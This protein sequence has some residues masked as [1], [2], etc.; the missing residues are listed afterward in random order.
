MAYKMHYWLVVHLAWV[1]R[2]V[3][4]EYFGLQNSCLVSSIYSMAIFA[5]RTSLPV[6]IMLE[7]LVTVNYVVKDWV[8]GGS[9]LD[10]WALVIT[11]SPEELWK[12]LKGNIVTGLLY[13]LCGSELGGI[14]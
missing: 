9:L 14:M 1:S 5:M 12:I 6:E 11:R 10:F 8:L 3:R 2:L 7:A 13:L 4:R